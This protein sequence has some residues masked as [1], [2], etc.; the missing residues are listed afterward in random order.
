MTQ[1]TVRVTCIATLVLTGCMS[2]PV[3]DGA[4][5]QQ[6]K[7][8][9]YALTGLMPLNAL[10]EKTRVGP[11][12]EELEVSEREKWRRLGQAEVF[13]VAAHH[14]INDE[15]QLDLY[16]SSNTM[17]GFGGKQRLVD[18]GTIA[19]ALGLQAHLSVFSLLFQDD[20][21]RNEENGEGFPTVLKFSVPFWFGIELDPW[22]SLYVNTRVQLWWV[23][24]VGVTGVLSQ[25]A[26]FRFGRSVGVISECTYNYEPFFRSSGFQIAFALYFQTDPPDYR[27]HTR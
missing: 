20:N 5:I 8:W 1:A 2:S 15:A 27:M 3:L 7:T 6:A 9:R 22:L 17:L 26:G 18:D 21:D 25:T 11:D 23:E 13:G 16:L 14:G 12:G 4:R 24:P 19:L 10:P